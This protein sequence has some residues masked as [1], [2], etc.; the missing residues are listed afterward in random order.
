MTLK[1][2][3]PY[4]ESP[5]TIASVKTLVDGGLRIALDLPEGASQIAA[6]LIDWR[7]YEVRVRVTLAAAQE[8]EK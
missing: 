1:R 4:V 2:E 3:L 5:A 8:E 7:G 6:A